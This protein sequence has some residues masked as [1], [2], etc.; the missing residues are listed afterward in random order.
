MILFLHST[1]SGSFCIFLETQEKWCTGP[2]MNS[3]VQ[4]LRWA[5]TS[6]FDKGSASKVCCIS[7]L[8]L[9]YAQAIIA[10]SG[11]E[12]PEPQSCSRYYS[13]LALAI[14]KAFSCP[15]VWVQIKTR[16]VRNCEKGI[17]R[18]HIMR[19][20]RN[21]RTKSTNTNKTLIIGVEPG[22]DI[23]WLSLLEYPACV[24]PQ[25]THCYTTCK[26]RNVHWSW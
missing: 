12:I 25:G 8:C 16:M 1:R 22:Q 24:A 3:R 23:P 6:L 19:R 2:S 11:G 10:D 18:L 4:N 20:E 21:K 15:S 5:C 17:S 9:S 7:C 14:N 26:G 13:R